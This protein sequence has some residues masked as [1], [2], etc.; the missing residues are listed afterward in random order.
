MH[1]SVASTSTMRKPSTEI[2]N[3]VEVAA[4]LEASL[5]VFLLLLFILI[6]YLEGILRRLVQVG[7]GV[8]VHV[9]HVVNTVCPSLS[10][11][12]DQ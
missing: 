5:H 1:L 9:T 10:E 11:V 6:R 12:A 3:G 4:L 2:K 7:E 8:S